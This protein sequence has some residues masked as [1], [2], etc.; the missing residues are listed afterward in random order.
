M[1]GWHLETVALG[2]DEDEHIVASDAELDAKLELYLSI[3]TT[4]SRLQRLIEHYQDRILSELIKRATLGWKHFM[5][6]WTPPDLSYEENSMGRFLKEYGKADKTKAGEFPRM[7]IINFGILK[8]LR[9][10]K[11]F[12]QN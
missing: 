6:I 1:N 4:T 9:L 8:H 3:Q 7:I 10:C 12:C 2:K 5:L 11:D